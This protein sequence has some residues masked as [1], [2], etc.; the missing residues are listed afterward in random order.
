[1]SCEWLSCLLVDQLLCISV[2]S[3]DKHLSVNFFQSLYCLSYA[4]VNCFYSLDCSFLNTCMSYHV[5]VCEV[6]HDHII[7]LGLDCSNELVAYFVSAHFRFQ[8]ISSNLRRFHK[9][10]VLSLIRLFYST[11][12]EECYVSIFLC[13]CDTSLFQSIIC[14]ELSKCICNGF[15]YKCN[16]LILD[17]SIILCEA[18]KC[19]LH[20]VSSFK[21]V[22]AVITECSC[23]L[24]CSVRTEVEEYNGI[25]FFDCSCCSTVFCYNK[26]YYE[27]ICYI[28]IVRSLDSSCCGLCCIALSCN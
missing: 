7:V 5:R 21:S 27:L 19:S 22:K 24:S 10:S 9:D 8:V 14:K 1:M 13:L 15:F 3:T 26:R 20:S 23:E 12:E 16:C 18:Y 4:L 6:D 11:I 17:C 25:I 2:V 28:F